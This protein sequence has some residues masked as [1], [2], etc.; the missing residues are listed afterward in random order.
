MTGLKFNCHTKHNPNCD[1]LESKLDEDSFITY[2]VYVNG[3]NKGK[4]FFE[5]YYGANYVLG[6]NMRSHSRLYHNIKDVP[7]TRASAYHNLR[8]L[9]KSKY[10]K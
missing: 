6:S 10:S 9:F 3:P 4:D 8:S 2:G 7:K 1:I 5:Y